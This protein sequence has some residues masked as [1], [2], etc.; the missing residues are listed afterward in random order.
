MYEKTIHK[1]RVVLWRAC[2][3]HVCVSI[4]FRW[5]RWKP[6]IKTRCSNNEVV[7]LRN[8][9]CLSFGLF[10]VFP[11]RGCT[12]G[13]GRPGNEGSLIDPWVWRL[14]ILHNFEQFGTE[15]YNFWR[16]QWHHFVLCGCNW[17][18]KSSYR[19]CYYKIIHLEW[20]IVYVWSVSHCQIPLKWIQWLVNWQIKFAYIFHN[21]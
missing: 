9:C 2:V 5:T 16:F 19:H 6:E 10:S 1:Y 20:V 12:D 21:F 7:E 13:Q 8:K 4:Y 15:F 11:S 17:Q 18:E 14:I 3:V